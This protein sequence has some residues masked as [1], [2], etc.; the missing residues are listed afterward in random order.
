M[1]KGDAK[2]GQ[3][4]GFGVDEKGSQKMKYRRGVE[5]EIGE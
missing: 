1:Q 2:R 5:A 3:T 4:M